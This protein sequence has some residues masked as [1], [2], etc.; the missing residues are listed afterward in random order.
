MGMTL[1]A[2]PLCA[3]TQTGGRP[4]R[5]FRT[6]FGSTDPSRPNRHALDLTVS[7]SGATDNGLTPPSV[8]ES[9]AAS[10]FQQLYSASAQLAYVMRASGF[11]ANAGGSANLPYYPNAADHLN[12]LGYGANAGLTFTSGTT[13]ATASGSYIYSPYYAAALD[14]ANAP[15]PSA[16]PFDYASARSP[17]DQTRAGASLTRRLSRRTSASL[18]YDFSRMWFENGVRS[19]RSQDARLSADRQMSRTLRL[20]G[21]YAYREGHYTAAVIGALPL[22]NSSHD[23]DLGLGYAR[24]MPRGQGVSLDLAFGRSFASDSIIGRP[25]WRGSANI[26]RIFDGGW[27]AGGGI[28]RALRFDS[29]IQQPIVADIANA[30]VSGRFGQRVT[31]SLSGTYSNGE[32]QAR[33][34]RE[35]RARGPIEGQARPPRPGAAPGARRQALCTWR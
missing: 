16:Q 2:Q 21:S 34:P 6:L 27:T 19:N 14:P 23:V 24:A 25:I 28:S 11:S 13:S 15:A 17:N 22:A 30:N 29:V 32:G 3:Q 1:M 10:N 4:A 5:P 33:G 35:G 9:P 8:S 31:L 12:T 18:G 7:F 26:T 20:R